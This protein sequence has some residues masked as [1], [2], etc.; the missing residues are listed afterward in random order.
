MFAAI[1]ATTFLI[2]GVGM[3]FIGGIGCMVKAFQEDLACGLLYLFLPFY[4][5]YYVVTRWTENHPF[6]WLFVGGGGVGVVGLIFMSIGIYSAVS[7]MPIADNSNGAQTDF[8][9]PQQF[10]QPQFGTNPQNFPSFS[11]SQPTQP[12][13]PP[14]PPP[15]GFGTESSS[16]PAT[17]PS[18]SP[19]A[20]AQNNPANNPGGSSSASQPSSFPAGSPKRDTR[21]QVQMTAAQ[22]QAKSSPAPASYKFS[23]GELVY[24]EW[25][26]VWYEAEVL[27]VTDSGPPN[28]HWIGWSSTFDE[29]VE[30]NRVR[31]PKK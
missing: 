30:K 24:V 10:N 23:K 3:N 28:I 15:S 31:I 13:N 25:G 22:A 1:F 19:P 9:P 4:G 17:S 27:D 26:A 20:F 5:L 12:T 18:N 8:T 6:N 29:V 21:P 14:T 16:P 11:N 2:I 7:N